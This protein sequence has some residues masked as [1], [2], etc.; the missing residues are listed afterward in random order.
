MKQMLLLILVLLL[1][2]PGLCQDPLVS[3]QLEDV[4]DQ[5]QADGLPEPVGESIAELI[6][7]RINLNT[8]SAAE[9]EASGI[10]SPYQVYGL[11]R[12]R[13]ETGTVYS[14]YE[15]VTI[16]AYSR[17]FLEQIRPYVSFFDDP[18]GLKP[19]R[20]AGLLLAN[21]SCNFPLSNGYLLSEDSIRDYAG[22]PLKQSL[23][24]KYQSG[25]WKMGFALDKD[26]GERWTDR[27]RPEHLAGY[28]EYSGQQHLEKI[29][30]GNYRLHSGLGLVHGLGFRNGTGF[31][32]NGYRAHYAKPF[33][34][35]SEY[36][37]YQ[38]IYLKAGRGR[39]RASAYGSIM[40]ADVSFHNL[41]DPLATHSIEDALRTTGYHRTESE[42]NG[43]RLARKTA[44]GLNLA[45]HGERLHLGLSLSGYRSM[46]NKT[47]RDS[48]PWMLTD[49]S[50]MGNISVYTTMSWNR[51]L[52]FGESALDH[53]GH[54][55]VFSGAELDLNTA[56]AVCGSLRSYSPGFRSQEPSAYASGSRPE[57]E[58]GF[59]IGFQ[60]TPFPEAELLLDTDF[61]YHREGN[62]HS[63]YPGFQVKSTGSLKLDIGESGIMKF[64]VRRR[65]RQFDR[66]QYRLHY[67]VAVGPSLTISGRAEWGVLRDDGVTSVSKLVYQQ[68]GLTGDGFRCT[69]RLLMFDVDNWDNRIYA[70]EP[71]VRYNFRFP[72]Y[73]GKGLRNSVV[74]SVSLLRFM[75]I[76]LQAGSTH[77]AYR[78]TTGSGNDIRPGDR[79]YDME[80]QLEWKW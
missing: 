24:A 39:L 1:P 78:R 55:A 53:N 14:I 2:L 47:G 11:L 31:Q 30:V 63:D 29:I 54:V 67:A 66:T 48:V 65:W 79:V 9:L 50:V 17:R 75:K 34:S 62:Y 76:R 40:P 8:A 41:S 36:G 72:S 60:A 46:L 37:Y 56:M 57:N 61:V 59:N 51:L 43:R 21:T 18:A 22:S 70:Y 7:N 74:A 15:L 33:A 71:G 58:R 20:Q 23:R 45:M 32:L 73:Y 26:P 27:G 28:L 49:R 44:G 6:E 16:P 25:R 3:A 19:N 80:I 38:G 42:V 12:Y 10:F 13:E 5:Y 68:A 35:L 4:P 77:Y 52:L 69:F 64:M